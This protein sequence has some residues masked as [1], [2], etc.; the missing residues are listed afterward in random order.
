MFENTCDWI[1][2][3]NTDTGGENINSI[4]VPTTLKIYELGKPLGS[5]FFFLFLNMNLPYALPHSY[6]EYG[7]PYTV[8]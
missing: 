7:I 3:G 5:L 1:T 2:Q 8:L 6:T 4:V